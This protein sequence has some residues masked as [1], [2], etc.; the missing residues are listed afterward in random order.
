MEFPGLGKLV[1][2][3][4]GRI[5][6]VFD[7]LFSEYFERESYAVIK[8]VRLY[9]QWKPV[10]VKPSA[11]VLRKVI[12]VVQD[13]CKAVN[14]ESTFH[15]LHMKSL[16]SCAISLCLTPLHSPLVFVLSRGFVTVLTHVSLSLSLASSSP[17]ISS[18]MSLLLYGVLQMP[19]SPV[20]FDVQKGMAD[21]GVHD[22][23][24]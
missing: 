1:T 2:N 17:T 21:M 10:L 22:Q 20:D 7:A 14:K 3:R 8:E 5:E 11:S 4:A 15:F 18:D 16:A 24:R 12:P 23:A 13:V 6:F 9:Y 19:Y